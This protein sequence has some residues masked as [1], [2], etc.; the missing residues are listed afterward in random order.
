MKKRRGYRFVK[1]L[2][3]I[4]LSFIGLCVLTPLFIVVAII[5]II[6]SGFPVFYLH[7]RVGKNKKIFNMLKFRSMKVDHRPIEEQLNA[8]Q[9][10]EYR[11]SYKVTNDPR[12]TKFGKFLRKTSI[13]ELPQLVNIFIGQMSFVG[14]RPVI[15][16]ELKMFKDKADIVTSV[17]PGLTGYWAVNGRS[18][19]TDYDDRVKLEAYYVEHASV[20]LDLKI[21]FK[22][23]AVVFTGKGAQ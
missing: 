7:K 23:F 13:D 18:E 21:I 22:T 2:F 15:D 17:K 9:L 11:R 20:G 12:L 3:D 1:R 19:V 4:I 14:P 10:E 6:M 5:Q 8:E 16:E